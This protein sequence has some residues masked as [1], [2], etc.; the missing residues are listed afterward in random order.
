MIDGHPDK[1]D[2]GGH[3]ELLLTW[4]IAL[5]LLLGLTWLLARVAGKWLAAARARAAVRAR[6]PIRIL[7]R[8]PL[9]P[10]HRLHVVE[11]GGKTLLLASFDGGVSLLAEVDGAA[12]A[13]ALEE[14]RY[15]D[16]R[17]FQE[18]LRAAI[19]RR[20]VRDRPAGNDALPDDEP[21]GGSAPGAE[22]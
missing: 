8:A 18:L 13:R 21:G 19:A 4:L 7:A 22:R 11:V 15:P 5:G 16:R 6:G 17:S 14:S 1:A 12:V 2:V 10:A 3:G 9:S 20:P